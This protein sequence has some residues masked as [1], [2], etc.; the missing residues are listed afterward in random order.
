MYG[1][2]QLKMW[3][4][5][6]L[7]IMDKKLKKFAEFINERSGEDLKL[8]RNK[9]KR[10]NR[11]DLATVKGEIFDLIEIAYGEIGGHVKITKP[12]D[13]LADKD[14]SFW[15]GIDI[16]NSPDLDIIIWGQETKYGIKYSG[17]GHDGERDSKRK[18]LDDRARELSSKG[19]FIEVSGKIAEILMGKYHVPFVTGL[20]N[21]EKILNKKGKIEYHGKHPIDSTI[22]G[23]GWYTRQLGGSSHIKIVLGKPKL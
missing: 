3:L 13:I 20:E 23:D 17:V 12:D 10:L 14:W 2:R 4:K 16:H 5:I 6:K 22:P 1:L 7:E 9:W 11:K 18:Y 15:Q 21:I 8:V 19:Y